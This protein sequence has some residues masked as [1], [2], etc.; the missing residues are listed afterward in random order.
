MKGLI[1]LAIV[2]CGAVF[3]PMVEAG[4]CPS[5]FQRQRNFNSGGGNN[6]NVFFSQT[7]RGP[8]GRVRSQTTFSR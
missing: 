6:G 3:S 2:L 4:N 7:I 5:N 8:G 1:L